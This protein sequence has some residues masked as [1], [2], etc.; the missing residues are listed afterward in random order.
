MT[1]FLTESHAQVNVDECEEIATSYKIVSMPTFVFIKKQK[2]LD[3]ISGVN[4]E[5][6][7]DLIIKHTNE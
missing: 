3:R 2:I 7:Q 5:V 4:T 6:L 1:V